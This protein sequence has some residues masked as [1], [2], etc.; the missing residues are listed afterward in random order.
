MLRRW[1]GGRSR[2]PGKGAGALAGVAFILTVHFRLPDHV[3]NISDHTA[4]IV[5]GVGLHLSRITLVC[6]LGGP[7][8]VD[9]DA[10]VGGI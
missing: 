4:Q 5:F 10:P 8:P 1:G 2:N 9:V 3:V 7:G 6:G